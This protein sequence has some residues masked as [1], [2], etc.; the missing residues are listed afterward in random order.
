[1]KQKLDI[2]VIHWYD[3]RSSDPWQTIEE[4]EVKW[5]KPA[6][7]VSVGALVERTKDLLI[8][9]QNFGDGDLCGWMQIPRAWVKYVKKVG[10]V[11]LNW[12][13]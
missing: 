2:L 4:A 10:V 6:K 11:D 9:C 1:M 13:K 5:H 7:V 12:V 3:A 8:I